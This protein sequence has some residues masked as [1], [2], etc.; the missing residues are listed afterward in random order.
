MF[1]EIPLRKFQPSWIAVSF[2]PGRSASRKARLRRPENHFPTSGRELVSAAGMRKNGQQTHMIIRP[3]FFS[4]AFLRRGPIYSSNL[5]F[6]RSQLCRPMGVSMVPSGAGFPHTKHSYSFFVT[7]S[8]NWAE[9]FSCAGR[10][11]AIKMTPLVPR[12]KRCTMPG[13]VSD[14]EAKADFS[15]K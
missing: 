12:S 10:F 11:F 9:R 5:F 7:R 2:F 4:T 14:N 6:F 1:P 15:L 3:L 8:L 13:R